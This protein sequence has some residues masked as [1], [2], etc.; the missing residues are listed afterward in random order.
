MKNKKDLED[1]IWSIL[2]E[3]EDESL[4]DAMEFELEWDTPETK[5]I[6]F[7]ALSFLDFS[8]CVSPASSVYDEAIKSL[9]AILL[10]RESK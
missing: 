4:E 1:L 10:K 2:C 9:E 7:D 6:I 8:V 3:A 5:S